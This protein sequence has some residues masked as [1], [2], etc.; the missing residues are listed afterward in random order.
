MPID[1]TKAYIHT[2]TKLEFAWFTQLCDIN[3]RLN[4]Y[5]TI[6]E[7][8]FYGSYVGARSSL[9]APQLR[10]PQ[11]RGHLDRRRTITFTD[12]VAATRNLPCN[13]VCIHALTVDNSYTTT[14]SNFLIYFNS[15]RT[16]S[17]LTILIGHET[18]LKLDVRCI[19]AACSTIACS[20]DEGST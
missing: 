16:G 2:E 15:I 18:M 7:E 9:H 5:S 3:K 11:I 1:S 17:S 6:S 20:P 10:A 14:C 4:I 13:Q 12:W 8:T 19:L